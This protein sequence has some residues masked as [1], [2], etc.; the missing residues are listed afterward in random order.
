MIEMEEKRKRLAHLPHLLLEYTNVCQI[1]ERLEEYD[2]NF[3][4][5]FNCVTQKHEVHC[6]GNLGSS[7]CFTVPFEEVDSR[8]LNMVERNDL[9]KKRLK[10]IIHDID[11]HNEKVERQIAERRRE[12]LRYFAID[13]RSVFKRFAEEVY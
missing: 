11:S 4:L 8:T 3:F 2:P 6:L 9:K 10:D 12:E 1:P 13:N 7:Y 5:V